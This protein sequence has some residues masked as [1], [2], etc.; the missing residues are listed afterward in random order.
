M[1]TIVK[2]RKGKSLPGALP[3]E[4]LG[5]NNQFSINYFGQQSCTAIAERSVCSLPNLKEICQNC[6]L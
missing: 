3:T 4:V 2:G 5:D 1:P 6:D